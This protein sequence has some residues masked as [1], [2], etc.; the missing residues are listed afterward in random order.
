MRALRFD[1]WPC[2]AEDSA[3]A[4]TTLSRVPWVLSWSWRDG[5]LRWELVRDT[6][7]SCQHL[8]IKRHVQRAISLHV[9]LPWE[10]A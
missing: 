5:L 10:G 9:A 1:A 3:N 4:L 7:A 8:A 6:D 2:P